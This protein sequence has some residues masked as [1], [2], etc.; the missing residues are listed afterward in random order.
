MPKKLHSLE[1]K[2]RKTIKKHGMLSPGELVLAAVSGG[3]D[4]VA[5][6]L[7]LQRLAEELGISIAVA[8]LNHR[9]RGAEA[10]AD[11]EF[12]RQLSA[13]LSLP[14][15]SEIVEIKKQAAEMRENL[16]QFA[17]RV[18][19]SFLR[20]TAS[21]LNARKIALG[22]NLNDQ[23]ETLLFRL[24]RGSGIQGLSAIHP[25]AGGL[26]IRP[27]LNCTRT[28]IIKYLDQKG[29]SHRED[30]TNKDPG[31]TRN[32]IRH[33]LLPL[34]EKSYNPSVAR[35]L[36]R[37]AGL[38]RGAWSFIES[39][40][41]NS[42]ESIHIA[43]DEGVSLPVGEITQLH[44]ELQKQVLRFALK[45]CRGSLSGIS[46]RHIHDILSLCGKQSGSRQKLPNGTTVIRQFDKLSILKRSPL[47][48]PEFSY[49]LGIPGECFIPEIKA[50]VSAKVL[51]AAP[52]RVKE[53]SPFRAILEATALPSNLTIRSKKPGDCYGGPGHKKVK[54]MFIDRKIPSAIRPFLPMVVV[55]NSVVWVP[56]FRP[57]QAFRAKTASATCVVLE[58]EKSD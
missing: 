54:K 53:E 51:P 30:S 40:A 52:E 25:V 9:I 17:R 43:T 12:V 4:S 42:F 18:R 38:I 41:K 1:L 22:H 31:Y 49:L 36:S 50:K 2:I 13:N 8:H 6:L 47:P 26:V 10:D 5:L 56:G 48:C 46:S 11:Q 16:E 27:L 29:A 57:A 45:S 23:A 55:G 15:F 24:L 44:P 14:F 37:T 35:T 20:N 21:I 28:E 33:E 39:E 7:C 34:L 19:Y 58:F 3:A 32:R